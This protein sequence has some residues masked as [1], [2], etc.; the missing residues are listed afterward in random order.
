MLYKG[1]LTRA[2]FNRAGDNAEFICHTHG[3]AR[4]GVRFYSNREVVFDSDDVDFAAIQRA[5]RD[6]DIE[7]TPLEKGEASRVD[8]K[9]QPR[10]GRP[11]KG[12][13]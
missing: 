13:E 12:A 7:I 10:R 6:G 3:H 1:K 9:E 2:F 11:P 8:F 5:V 4:G